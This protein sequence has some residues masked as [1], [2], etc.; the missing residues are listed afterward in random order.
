MT[1]SPQFSQG[2]YVPENISLPEDEKQFKMVLK[3]VLEDHARLINRKDT[4]QYE[5]VEIQNNQTYFSL[6]P[7]KKKY[8]YRKVIDT[9]AL[10]NSSTKSVNHGITGI[11][12]DTDFVRIY[13]VAKQPA[14]A[15]NRPYFI[16]MPNSGPNYSVELMIDTVQIHITTVVDLT[17]FSSSF[18]VLEFI[19]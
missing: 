9:G 10:P 5:N 19:K 16:P 1:S 14:G 3:R 11:T 6:N 12:N 7:Q 17:A 15:P 8:V 2:N 13:G 4:G 18:I